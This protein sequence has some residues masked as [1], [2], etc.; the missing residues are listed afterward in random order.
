MTEYR[1]AL[2]AAHRRLEHLEAELE[3]RGLAEA[4]PTAY[5]SFRSLVILFGSVLVATTL[6]AIAT[7]VVRIHLA[8]PPRIV[9]AETAPPTPARPS[10]SGLR[11]FD[12]HHWLEGG[13]PSFRDV[14]GDGKNEIFGVAWD[15]QVDTDGLYAVAIDRKDLAL[16]WRAGPFPGVWPP[17]N[18]ELHH[19]VVLGDRVVVTDAR[20]GVHVLAAEDGKA[21]FERTLG[22]AVESACASEDGAPRI[23]LATADYWRPGFPGD[24]GAGYFPWER[25]EE[26]RMLFDPATGKTSPAPHALGCPHQPT[27]CS[28]N[29]RALPALVDRCRDLYEKLPEW[30]GKDLASSESWRSGDDRVTVGLGGARRLVGWSKKERRIRWEASLV[31][32]RG[33]AGES[34]SLSAIGDGAFAHVYGRRVS[35]PEDP[36]D[37]CPIDKARSCTAKT[38][39]SVTARLKK[40]LPAGR[41]DYTFDLA[42]EGTRITVVDVAPR[43]QLA[44]QLLFAFD[45]GSG[46]L[47]WRAPVA[48]PPRRALQSSTSSAHLWIALGGRRVLSLYLGG[49]AGHR[50]SAHDAERGALLYDVAMPSLPYG[51][52]VQRLT[53]DGDVAFVTTT[54]GLHVVDA[55]RG[56]VTAKIRAP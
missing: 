29:P 5:V 20:G 25:N 18:V 44:E 6:G 40:L 33:Y 36:S 34:P 51:T 1:S 26:A 32:D 42:D 47:H 15:R 46:A 11:W 31:E 2:R 7:V 24:T 48:P 8:P 27:Y 23:F 4:E 54:G 22:H 53:V 12:Q 43:P 37:A 35:A 30:I 52:E 17:G 39:P 14:D 9:D 50:L 28:H 10:A 21:L 41:A 55:S 56:A 19:L 45:P 38:P 16:R 3:R 49:S 13:G